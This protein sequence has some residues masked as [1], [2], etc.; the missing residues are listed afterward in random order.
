MMST[1]ITIA[2]V[3]HQGLTPIHESWAIALKNA[4]T[5][6]TIAP[7][8][9]PPRTAKPAQ[10]WSTPQI[11]KNQPQ[12]SRFENSS[13]FTTYFESEIAAI[14][15][16]TLKKPT[17]TSMIPAKPIQPAPGIARAYMSLVDTTT[18]FRYGGGRAQPAAGQRENVARGT[19][20]IHP[21]NV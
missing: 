4:V 1:S 7:H 2:I 19:R 6:P 16:I 21:P 3:A 14:P 12:A 18:P 9:A 13:W 15:S 11:R 10:I 17:R 5:M 20:A 8:A